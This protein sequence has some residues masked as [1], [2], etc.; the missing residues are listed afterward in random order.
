[1]DVEEPPDGGGDSSEEVR[2]GIKRPKDTSGE[3]PPKRAG[4]PP[5]ASIQHTFTHPDFDHGSKLKFSEHDAAPFI[6][7][8]SRVE[9]DPSAGLTIRLLKFAQF[10]YKKSVQGIAKDGIRSAGRNR[11][12]VQ[13]V[14][15]K[16]A[17]DFLDNSLLSE[18]KYKAVIPSYHITRMG[19]VRNIPIDWTLEELVLALECPPGCRVVKARRLNRKS[20]KDGQTEWVPTQTVVLTFLSQ[21]LPERVFCFYTSLPVGIYT[22]PTIQCNNCCRFGHIKSQCRSKPK[23][24]RCTQPHPGESCTVPD[25]K[26]SCLFCSGSHLATYANCPEHLRQKSIKLVMSEESIPYSE[27][28]LRFRPVRRTFRDTAAAESTPPRPPMSPLSPTY[29]AIESPPS[30]PRSTTYRKTVVRNRW[31]P[32]PVINGYNKEF[33]SQATATPKSSQPNG[34]ALI[35]SNPEVSFT[36]DDIELMCKSL[37]HI[38]SRKVNH[39]PNNIAVM[40]QHLRTLLPSISSTQNGHSSAVEQQEH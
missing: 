35:N 27:A 15:A 24:F 40:L 19:I 3:T 2:K 23:C 11:V 13:F 25:E 36:D 14:D 34:C 21:T 6:V 7:H 28:S 16:S 4:V 39:L 5:A 29:H 26:I 20:V 9:E 1:M 37:I 33:H 18:N 8:V 12:V 17:N 30:T 22:L 32:A 10:L 38:L 31:S